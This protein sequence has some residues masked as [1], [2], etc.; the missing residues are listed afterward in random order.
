M[1]LSLIWFLETGE[2][3]ENVIG[4]AGAAVAAAGGGGGAAAAIIVCKYLVAL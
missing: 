2:V 1:N 4:V 3:F